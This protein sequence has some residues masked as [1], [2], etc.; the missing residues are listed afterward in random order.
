MP[1]TNKKTCKLCD[2][3][4]Y[5]NQSYCF[6]HYREREKAKKEL[7]A[8]NK[9]ERHEKTKAF[10]KEQ[11]NKLIRINDKLYQ[12]IGRLLNK[13]CFAGHEY[14][15]LHHLVRKKTC[16][17]LRWDLANGMPICNAC[18]CK[19]HNGQDVL[20][21]AT[22]IHQHWLL[23]ELNT[24]KREVISDKLSFCLSENKRLKE[25]KEKYDSP[26]L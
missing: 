13:R 25:L 15:C 18:H 7:K 14:S 6:K 10:S 16:L 22:Y 21:E 24:K 17:K 23:D 8:K 19:I 5:A 26:S 12:E 1:K 3:P 20:S 4:R 11:I 9:K 2:K